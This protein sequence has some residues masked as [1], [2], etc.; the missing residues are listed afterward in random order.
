MIPTLG[1]P[2]VWSWLGH[3][4]ARA[5]DGAT[6]EDMT[7]GAHLCELRSDG[8]CVGAFA[9]EFDGRG[10]LRVTALAAAPDVAA[11]RVVFEWVRRVARMAD[12]PFIEC[13]TR[14]PELVR[15]LARFG[16]VIVGRHG[17]GWRV[18]RGIA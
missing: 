2:S 11:V 15:L 7:K 13:D 16:C 17:A 18:A 12:V 9:W 10:A 14:R 3:A 6:V 8:I 5:C 4:A 1:G